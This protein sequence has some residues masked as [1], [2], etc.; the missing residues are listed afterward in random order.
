MA[1]LTEFRQRLRRR[2]ETAVERAAPK[3]EESLVRAAPRDTGRLAD[4]VEVTA[5]GLSALVGVP[6]D[7]ATFTTEG[8]QPHRIIPRNARV[9]A[10]AWPKKGPGIFFFRSVNHPGTTGQ[11]WYADQTSRWPNLVEEELNRAD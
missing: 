7:Y 4:S 10:F 3:L 11:P 1:D 5:R 2:W 8:T 9:L 6:V